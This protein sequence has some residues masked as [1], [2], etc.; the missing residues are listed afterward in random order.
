MSLINHAKVSGKAAGSDATLVGGP[1]WDA[2]HTINLTALSAALKITIV[3]GNPNGVTTGAIGDLVR[4]TSTGQLWTNTNGTTGWTAFVRADGQTALAR[5]FIATIGDSNTVGQSNTDKAGGEENILVPNTNVVYDDFYSVASSEPLT[6]IH[7]TGDLRIQVVS[8]TPGYGYEI[9]MGKALYEIINGVGTPATAANKVWL[10]K[11]GISGTTLAQ[12]VSASYGITTFGVTL[13]NNWKARMLAIQAASGRTLG[14]VVVNLGTNDAAGTTDANNMAANI[15]TLISRIRT[16]FGNQVTIIW[17]KTHVSTGNPQVTTVRA[18]IDSS[19]LGVANSAVI[20]IDDTTILADA[21]HYE[22][23]S[24]WTIGE[25]CAYTL[26]SVQGYPKRTTTVNPI[27]VGYGTCE[28]NSGSG[29][30]SLSPRSW[31]GTQDGDTMYLF[32]L[33]TWATGTPAQPATASGWTAIDGAIIGPFSGITSVWWLWRRDVLQ[34]D[35]VNGHTPPPAITFGGAEGAIQIFT[36][37]GV[38]RFPAQDGSVTRLAGAAF[39]TATVNAAGVTTALPNG[40]VL[41]FIAGLA[42]G[43]GFGQHLNV[44]GGASAALLKDAPY[45]IATGNYLSIAVAQGIKTVAG[46]TGTVVVTPTLSTTPVGVTLA[47]HG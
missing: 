3:N 14:A 6:F 46:A 8:T 47:L 11:M 21:L 45:N 35:F 20:Q 18:A 19:M 24:S 12:W 28:R 9:A 40:L 36:A 37:R 7:L 29:I 41:T 23:E 39:S 25:R 13:Y 34:A 32:G 42:G 26:A 27:I 4:D 10:A 17:I 30:T 44:S 22:S 43:S 15:T 2:D 31:P 5:T 33:S 16:D 1:D 38:G